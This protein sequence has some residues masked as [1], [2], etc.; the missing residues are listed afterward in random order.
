ME[1]EQGS[2]SD[3]PLLSEGARAVELLTGGRTRYV[4]VRSTTAVLEKQKQLVQFEH[5]WT[6]AEDV[7]LCSR[8]IDCGGVDKI[9]LS[10]SWFRSG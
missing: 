4:K 1:E 6:L 7:K 2:L 9:R 5:R 8:I 3:R 10:P